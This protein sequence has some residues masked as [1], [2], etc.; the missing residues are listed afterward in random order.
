MV[1]DLNA[2]YKTGTKHV[3]QWLANAALQQGERDIFSILPALEDHSAKLSTQNLVDLSKLLVQGAA[4]DKLAPEGI[5]DT[6]LVLGDVIAGR[7][8]CA[9][10]YSHKPTTS[11]TNSSSVTEDQ[12]HKHFIGVLQHVLQHLKDTVRNSRLPDTTTTTNREAEGNVSQR[13]KLVNVYQALFVEEPQVEIPSS[14]ARKKKRKPS[15]VPVKVELESDGAAEKDFELWCFLREC[16]NIRHFVRDTWLRQQRGEISVDV[17]SQVSVD[18]PRSD[19]IR[20]IHFTGHDGC[21]LAT[22]RQCRR[23]QFSLP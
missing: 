7:R 1:P 20:L 16:Y 10:W 17:A 2:R 6:I 19:R 14:T 12:T 22:K 5:G 9:D 21:S 15:R 11:R 23:A 18:Y 13:R 3:V 8:E 4:T